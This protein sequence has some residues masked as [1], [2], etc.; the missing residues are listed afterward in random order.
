M[1]MREANTCVPFSAVNRR[2]LAARTLSCNIYCVRTSPR[3]HTAPAS[4]V[5]PPPWPFDLPDRA[6]DAHSSLFP[7]SLFHGAIKLCFQARWR[8][9]VKVTTVKSSAIRYLPDPQIILTF[10]SQKL[11]GEKKLINQSTEAALIPGRSRGDPREEVQ[12]AVFVSR[13]RSWAGG[14]ETVKRSSCFAR[15]GVFFPPAF[16]ILTVSEAHRR[17]LTVP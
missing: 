7:L 6:P 16:F 2:E 1:V 3:L 8:L 5:S 14:G 10:P 17:E 12:T 15:Q 13:A 11:G 9:K 4:S